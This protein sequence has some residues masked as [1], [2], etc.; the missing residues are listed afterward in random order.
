MITIIKFSL[1]IF[2]IGTLQPFA[3]ADSVLMDRLKTCNVETRAAREAAAAKAP[4]DF[5]DSTDLDATDGLDEDSSK[6][7]SEEASEDIKVL[8]SVQKRIGHPKYI[9]GKYFKVLFQ[10]AS[11]RPT[12]TQ[13]FSFYDPHSYRFEPLMKWLRNKLPDN[14]IFQKKHVSFM[15]GTMGI[16]MSKAYATMVELDI[17]EKMTQV[18]FNRIHDMHKYPNNDRELRQIFL[19][20]EANSSPLLK[21]KFQKKFEATFK[22]FEVDSIVR[23]MDSQF[24]E[25]SLT[26]LPAIVVNEK[27]LIQTPQISHDEYLELVNYLLSKD[28]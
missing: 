9:E 17:E 23:S 24:K 11:K 21:L 6:E 7:S 19:D 12:V 3:L 14:V 18:L 25:Y 2:I 4:V 27:Y 8:S 20:T 13:F 10:D 26:G 5:D 22:S 15:G 1:F 16:S 28:R